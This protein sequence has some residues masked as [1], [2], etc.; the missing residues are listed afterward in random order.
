MGTGAVP[1]HDGPMSAQP[2]RL[3]PAAAEPERAYVVVRTVYVRPGAPYVIAEC[4]DETVW[5]AGGYMDTEV[6]ERSAM[7]AEPAMRAALEAW[8]TGDGDLASRERA[9]SERAFDEEKRTLS[10]TVDVEDPGGSAARSGG[11][12]RLHS[13]I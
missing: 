2:F 1:G 5:P 10:R 9:A 4:A 12:R 8:E 3:V 6:V 11:R 7:R 13:V